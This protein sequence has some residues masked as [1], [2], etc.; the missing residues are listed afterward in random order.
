MLKH[1]PLG[2]LGATLR[3]FRQQRGISVNQLAKI[4]SVSAGMIS[5]IERGVANPSVKILERLR[6]ALDV[7][8]SALFESHHD[9]AQLPPFE[10][11]YVRRASDRATLNVGDAFLHKEMLS[12]FSTEGLEVMIIHMPAN[13]GIEE[14][15]VGTGQKAGLVLKGTPTLTIDGNEIALEEGDS[16][17]FPSK[18]PHAIQNTSA[19]EAKALWIKAP[20]ADDADD[21]SSQRS[22]RVGGTSVR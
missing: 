8:L 2:H 16:F 12:P 13:S 1:G 17:Q 18:L 6:V 22:P 21:R 9:P 7:P 20:Y 14:L 4:S 15:V 10:A 19:G 3:N 11:R 5:Q